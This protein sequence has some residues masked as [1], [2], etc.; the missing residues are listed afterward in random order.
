MTPGRRAI[1][2]ASILLGV[3][4]LYY[5]SNPR[6]P[7]NYKHHVY[8]ADAWLHGRLWVKGY[9]GH[10]HD[11]I[12]VNGRM[13]SPFAPTPAILLL[14]F[15]WWWGTAFN[16]NAFSMGVAGLNAA[17]CWLLL[18]Q[19]G[20]GPRRA[21]L[22]TL[23]YAFGTVN[24]FGAIIGTTW[25]LAQICAQLFL[26][27]AL[28]EISGRGRGVL[29]GAAAGFAVLSRP[30]VVAAMPG[31]ALLLIDRHA[32]RTGL[33]RFMDGGAFRRAFLF[34]A[35]L[36]MPL[37][38]EM[39]LNYARFGNP[40]DT[41]YDVAS[42][43]YPDR[44]TYG[45]MYDIRYL[46]KHMYVALFRGWEYVDELPFL[47][48]SPE[49]LSVVYTSP[50]LVYALAAPWRDRTVRLLWFA[51]ALTGVLIV[52]YF[53]QGWVQFGY[54]YL[55]DALPYVIILTAVGMAERPRKAVLAL[56]VFSVLSNALGVYWGEKLG[57]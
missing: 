28:L 32:S 33:R 38:I 45:G 21:A 52:P 43:I 34:A 29:V 39:A 4:L 56:M 10:Y 26:L 9:P 49:G 8:V 24:W 20:V 2:A 18:T 27:L 15:V 11:W 44:L 48:P 47:K 51:T 14:P 37:T 55:L 23:V 36:A 40:L 16:M 25:F 13:H 42:K 1:A 57:W 46:S 12:T 17:L 54:R 31:I 22:G 53:T 30:N 35:G 3:A 5:A 19:V 50:I 41:G 6:L 7:D